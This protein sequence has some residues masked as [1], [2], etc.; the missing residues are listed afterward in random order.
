MRQ[1]RTYVLSY[2]RHT[3]T[4]VLSSPLINTCPAHI[5][6]ADPILLLP[7]I[8]SE[9]TEEEIAVPDH[10]Q[11][12]MANSTVG[13]YGTRR[14]FTRSHGM[15][16]HAV[17]QL[18][19][20]LQPHSFVDRC[21]FVVR[22]VHTMFDYFHNTAKQDEESA[23][24]LA[25]WLHK[26][27]NTIQGGIPPSPGAIKTA[28]EKFPD[29]VTNL[30]RC[31]F[32]EHNHNHNASHPGTISRVFDLLALTVIRHDHT[33]CEFVLSDPKARWDDKSSRH[34]FTVALDQAYSFAN[35]SVEERLA[36]QTEV[37][38][39]FVELNFNGLPINEIIHDYRH[40]K[41][42]VRSLMM[43][44]NNTAQAVQH[45]SHLMYSLLT[46]NHGLLQE[47]KILKESV[48]CLQKTLD[49]V[50]HN[51]E[52]GGNSSVV[53]PVTDVPVVVTS[54]LVIKNRMEAKIKPQE[55]FI[56]WHLL[57]GKLSYEIF[58]ENNKIL[59]VMI[60][61]HSNAN[62]FSTNMMILSGMK[63]PPRPLSSTKL[64]I[65][66]EEIVRSIA[67]EAIK[68]ANMIGLV[69]ITQIR[70]WKNDDAS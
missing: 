57:Q 29:F 42:D 61:C 6:F 32:I 21:G 52:F 64:L 8:G 62:Q 39:N 56:A 35:V 24:T 22:N 47:V 50:L 7:T 38:A 48:G 43:V 49:N 12:A 70:N 68:K 58:K 1:W 31:N 13:K 63:M 17:G 46:E 41:V 26:I 59:R 55:K 40:V 34:P 5:L 36:W 51:L 15:K 4:C 44:T 65:E 9:N 67:D 25:N 23:Q 60:N 66:W 10:F 33:F 20:H 54:W 3:C 16:R 27:N 45:N 14:S 19:E 30:F 37:K 53:E 18:Q 11:A 28:S 69:T 2:M